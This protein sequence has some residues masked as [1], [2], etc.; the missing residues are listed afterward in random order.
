MRHRNKKPIETP[1]KRY[2]EF[3]ELVEERLVGKAGNIDY[4]VRYTYDVSLLHRV[5]TDFFDSNGNPTNNP[6][7]W[8]VHTIKYQ[9][10]SDSGETRRI[11]SWFDA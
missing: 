11:D 9:K 5:E 3:G 7:G 8:S 1:N 2:G 6:D 10:E 4:I